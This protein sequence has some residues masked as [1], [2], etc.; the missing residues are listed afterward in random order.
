[1]TVQGVSYPKLVRYYSSVTV[2]Y[3]VTLFMAALLLNPRFTS[4]LLNQRAGGYQIAPKPAPLIPLSPKIISGKPVR[5]VVPSVGIDI[6]VI[7]GKYNESNGQWSLSK[8][9]AHFALIT[10]VANNIQG[11]TFIYGHYNKHVFLNLHK[12]KDDQKAYLYTDN[13]HVFSYRFKNHVTVGP[14]DTGVFDY[15]GAPILTIQTCTG[16]WYEKRQIFTFTFEGVDQGVEE[17]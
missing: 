6:E 5:L 2:V 17:S 11:N 14:T 9:R 1:M 7:D 15:R 13:D 3:A 8:D 10:T 4:E 12:I 16:T